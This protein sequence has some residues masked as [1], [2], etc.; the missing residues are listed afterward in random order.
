MLNSVGTTDFYE[1]AQSIDFKNIDLD[2]AIKEA[3]SY[4]NLCWNVVCPEKE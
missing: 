3:Q 1:L 2:A 4:E